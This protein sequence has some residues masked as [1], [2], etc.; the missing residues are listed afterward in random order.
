[1]G[2]QNG[3]IVPF[4]ESVPPRKRNR[5]VMISIKTTDKE[6]RIWYELPTFQPALLVGLQSS[7]WK[8]REPVLQTSCAF[9]FTT[10]QSLTEVVSCSS[11]MMALIP[12][13]KG[14]S[15]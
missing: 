5:K 8:S 12:K 3:H 7:P 13:A 1:M 2:T 4:L 10:V 14:V 11:L 6:V 15:T 9:A